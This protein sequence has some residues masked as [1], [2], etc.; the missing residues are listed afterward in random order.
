MVVQ[1]GV[2]EA[3]LDRSPEQAREPLR[4]VQETGQQAISELTR[5][6]G[7]LRGGSDDSPSQLAPQPGAAQLS[8]LVERLIAS[9]LD[10]RLTS[11]GDARALPPGV[12]LTVFR[13][14]QEALTNVLKHAGAGVCAHIELRYLP[15]ALEIEVTDDGT[16]K[17]S[18]TG[19]GHG[20]I[21]MAERVS[22]FG[23]CIESGARPEGGFRV[24]V[25]LPLE[26]K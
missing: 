13:I 9:G 24:F 18:R 11:V 12:D 22:V 21:G 4:A 15:H 25:A 10:V 16:A 2:S 26:S 20:L 7:L 5:M 1:A 23:G 17:P 14:V 3:L 19:S 8:E 6:L